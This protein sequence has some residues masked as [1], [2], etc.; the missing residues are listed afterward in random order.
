MMM[1]KNNS[2]LDTDIAR[3]KFLP[4]IS[5]ENDG[6]REKVLLNAVQPKTETTQ[7]GFT[8]LKA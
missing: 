6:S 3:Q 4:N 5:S 8:P 2:S 7:I 1:A